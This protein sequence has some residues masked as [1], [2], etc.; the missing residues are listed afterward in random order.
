M[1]SIGY[2]TI[3]SLHGS[4]VPGFPGSGFKF[5][6]GLSSRSSSG[7]DHQAGPV[8]SE[9]LRHRRAG[10]SQLANFFSKLRVV[11]LIVFACAF[12]CVDRTTII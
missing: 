11:S 7:Y 1:V 6:L 10:I 3:K 4:R 2:L 5:Q 12:Q 8:G 9:S